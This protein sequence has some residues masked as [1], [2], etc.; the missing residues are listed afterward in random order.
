MK[1]NKILLCTLVY[2]IIYIS[3]YYLLKAFNYTFLVWIKNLS[4]I[5][6]SIGI[7]AGSIQFTKNIRKDKKVLKIILYLLIIVL[8]GFILLVNFFY[9]VF[10]TNIEEI[11][12]YEGLR[13]L[14]ETRQVLKSNYIK[15]YDYTNPLIRSMQERVYMSYDDTISEDEYGGTTFYNK[16]GQEVEDIYGTEFIDVTTTT[17][18]NNISS[19]NRDT[20]NTTE[21][22]KNYSKDFD[23]T[24]FNEYMGANIS[25]KKTVELLNMFCNEYYIYLANSESQTGNNS[26]VYVYLSK[27]STADKM[28]KNAVVDSIES[29]LRVLD[30]S[31]E[32]TY[33][34]SVGTNK[35]YGEYIFIE[36]NDLKMLRGNFKITSKTDDKKGN[37]DYIEDFKTIFD[38]KEF[39]ENINKEYDIDITNNV[40]IWSMEKNNFLMNIGCE[41]INKDEYNKYS[42]YVFKTFKEFVKDKYNLDLEKTTLFN[43]VIQ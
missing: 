26:G 43:E 37:Y 12:E 3:I 14:K 28:L 1:K 15:Y 39:I 18:Q 13:M 27:N 7:I 31:V 24:V 20:V 36:R 30:D 2:A 33:N 40:K 4:V 10:I 6:I 23:I 41:G 34:I 16:E 42:E 32:A 17:T 19:T 29:Y 25:Y 38:S 22:N 11:S 9:F 5:L 35:T 21:E 8:T